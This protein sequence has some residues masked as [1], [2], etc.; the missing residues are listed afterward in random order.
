MFFR[1]ERIMRQLHLVAMFL[2]V[3]LCCDAVRAGEKASWKGKDVVLKRRGL[4]IGY[5]DASGRQVYVG[6][7]TDISYTVL[8][9]QDGWLKVKHQKAS[10]WFDKAE[11]MLP[12][13]AVKYF[14][15]MMRREPRSDQ[16]PA[17]RAHAWG[18]LKEHGKALEDYSLA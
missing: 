10:G 12:D 3:G 16:W 17:W 8:D 4:Q 18:M 11:A 1:T 5:T 6:K 9:D 7:L 15:D 14:T 2:L 13:E